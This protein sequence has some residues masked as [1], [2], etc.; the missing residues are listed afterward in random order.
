MSQNRIV[1]LEQAVALKTRASFVPDVKEVLNVAEEFAM[2]LEGSTPDKLKNAPEKRTAP[3]A[4][5]SKRN[6]T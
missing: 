2:F 4:G 6:P 1:A 5:K 3:V